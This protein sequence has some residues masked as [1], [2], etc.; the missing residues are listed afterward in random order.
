M[1]HTS[2]RNF[3]AEIISLCFI[4]GVGLFV[5]VMAWLERKTGAEKPNY[6]DARIISVDYM[7][8]RCIVVVELEDGTRHAFGSDIRYV[9]P[10]CAGDKWVVD[11]N[12]GGNSIR[13]V[14]RK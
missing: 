7:R 12:Q 2:R 10:P 3:R 1:T 13:L 9:D 6:V 11:K 4:I 14:R 8:R 5:C